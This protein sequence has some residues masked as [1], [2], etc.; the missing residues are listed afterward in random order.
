LG[1]STSNFVLLVMQGKRNLS[2]ETASRLAGVFKMDAAETECFETLVRFNQSKRSEEKERL[3]QKLLTYRKTLRL[4]RITDRQYEYY[5]QWYHPVVRELAVLPGIQGDP[6]KISDFL[7]PAVGLRQVKLSLSLLL[8]LGFLEKAGKGYV[9]ASP[10][11]STGPE[12]VSVAVAKFH[13]TM[14]GLAADAIDAFPRDARNLT[15]C[16][17]RISEAGYRRIVETLAE[18]RQKVLSIASQDSKTD[19]VC[20]LNLHFFPLTRLPQKGNTP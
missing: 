10:V 4:D 1:L 12:A 9:Q 18:C 5:S 19:R 16:T 20:Q 13:R 7:H 3:F 15:A 11:V 8:K 6:R 2:M 17:V 14:A